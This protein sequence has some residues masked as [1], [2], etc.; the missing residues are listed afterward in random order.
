MALKEHEVFCLKQHGA[1]GYEG[2]K[3]YK[4]CRITI[5]G[6]HEMKKSLCLAVHRGVCVRG[7]VARPQGADVLYFFFL[8][9]RAAPKLV[10]TN[11]Q[12][13]LFPVMV[14]KRQGL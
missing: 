1:M 10:H 14:A 7:R 8:K 13:I 9:C 5:H 4:L 11:I 12:L 2:V 6:T 3:W